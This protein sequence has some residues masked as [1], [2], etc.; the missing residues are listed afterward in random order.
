MNKSRWGRALGALALSLPML[1]AACGGSDKDTGNG[2][3]RVALTDAPSCGFDTVFV[4]VQKV[5]V[6]QSSSAAEGD[7]GWSEIVLNPAKRVELLSLQNG[8]LAEL[9][10]TPLAPGRYQQMRLVLAAND[11]TTPLANSV[12]PTG[13]SETALN[14]PSALQSGLK[15]NVDIDIESGKMADLVIDFDA[16]KSVV[17]T[18]NSG[19][20]NLKPVLKVTPRFVSG[21]QGFVDLT[22]ANGSTLVTLQQNGV[23]VRSTSPDSSGKFLLQP[24]AAGTYDLVL[25]APGHVTRVVT[26][27]T[28]TAD[29]V[30]AFNTAATQLTLPTATGSGT[31]NGTVTIA[32]ATTIDAS[33]RVTQALT[34]GPTVQIASA[35]VNSSTGAYSFALVTDAPQKAAYVSSGTLSFASDAAVAGKYSVEASSGSATKPAVAISLTN[36]ATVTTPF[37]FP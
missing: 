21:V 17:T 23:V 25:T 33:V 4:T 19:Q 2:S 18:G 37:A 6:H 15:M 5:R 34:G 29:T 31:A 28:V 36:G 24:V 1:L 11:A 13:G 12:T 35:A 32:G 20:Y 22:L 14:T 16:C 8:V 7:S 9:G 26:G 30:T 27:V 3:M 10:Q